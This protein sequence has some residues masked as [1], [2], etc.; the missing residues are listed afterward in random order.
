MILLGCFAGTT[1]SGN[2]HIPKIFWTG[3]TAKNWE[4]PHRIENSYV[5]PF[6]KC[7]FKKYQLSCKKN[8]LLSIILAVSY[9]LQKWDII[10]PITKGLKQPLHNWT[11]GMFPN[12][13]MTPPWY[14]FHMSHCPHGFSFSHMFFLSS[15]SPFP[16]FE[17]PPTEDH[18]NQKSEHFSDKKKV[19]LYN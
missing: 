2:T 7:V 15:R 9:G 1:I 11:F 14:N 5:Q 19:L 13:H 12:I 8:L 4:F 3:W 16:I 10:N 17:L 6:S 18:V